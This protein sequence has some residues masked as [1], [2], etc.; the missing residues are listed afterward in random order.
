MTT[1]L[2]MS[3]VHCFTKFRSQKENQPASSVQ[4]NC[5]SSNEKSPFCPWTVNVQVQW[6]IFLLQRQ[7]FS[8]HP[9]CCLVVCNPLQAEGRLC[10]SAKNSPAGKVNVTENGLGW[11]R[12]V[13]SLFFEL[14]LTQCFKKLKLSN[15]NE[16]Q[17]EFFKVFFS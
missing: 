15:G 14:F 4:C 13:S 5:V 16:G 10:N 11:Q 3:L 17:G 9:T 7:T 12:G 8:F 1:N 2:N 6:N